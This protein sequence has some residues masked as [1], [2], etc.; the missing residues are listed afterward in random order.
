MD[1]ITIRFATNK[2]KSFLISNRRHIDKSLLISKINSEEVY[3]ICE[4]REIIGW[5]RYNLFCDLTPFLTMI[6][7][8]ENF[9]RIGYGKKLI[10][11]WEKD[12]KSKKQKYLMTSTQADEQAQFFYHKLGFKDIGSIILP[13]QDPLEIFLIKEIS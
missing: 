6:Y 11:F 1:K 2:D 7:I 12:M 10:D 5:A 3:V 9:R 4:N 8:L 13:N